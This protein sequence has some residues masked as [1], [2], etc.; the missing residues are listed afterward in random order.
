MVFVLRSL[1]RE[2]HFDLSERP[3]EAHEILNRLWSCEDS[4]SAGRERQDGGWESGQRHPRGP[5][6]GVGQMGE[7]LGREEALGL[8]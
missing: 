3:W 1:G 2:L 6:W 5:T 8:S 7:A 4:G